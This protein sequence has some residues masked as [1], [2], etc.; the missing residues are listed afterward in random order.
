MQALSD[1]LLHRLAEE[2][3]AEVAFLVVR[4]VELVQEGRDALDVAFGTDR[5]AMS[6]EQPL[7]MVEGVE[8]IRSG[9]KGQP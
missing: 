7:D 8:E 9:A 2:G 5:V 4:V 1:A 3:V 6:Q